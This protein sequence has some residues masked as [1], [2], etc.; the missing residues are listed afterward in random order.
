MDLVTKEAESGK[1]IVHLFI[2]TLIISWI[3]Q[4]RARLSLLISLIFRTSQTIRPQIVNIEMSGDE[5]F[6]KTLKIL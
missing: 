5:I 4:N 6:Q 2:R 1:E 3:V